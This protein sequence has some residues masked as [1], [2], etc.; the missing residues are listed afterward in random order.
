MVAPP[1]LLHLADEAAT[2]ALG[3]RLAAALRPGLS[4]HLCG[5]LGTGKTTLVR[6][7]LRALGHAGKVK[8]PTYTLV[9]PYSVSRLPLYHFDFYRL[10]EPSEWLDAGFREYFN[11][12]SVCLV[13]WP[14]KAADL[15][16]PDLRLSLRHATTGRDVTMEALSPRGAAILRSISSGDA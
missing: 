4:I 8:S 7:C 2:Q 14:E 3:A 15:P 6:A 12:A 13:E 5:E 16:Q 1:L 10:R 9:E 11:A